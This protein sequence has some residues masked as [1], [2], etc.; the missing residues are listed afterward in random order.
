MSTAEVVTARNQPSD[1]KSDLNKQQD[2]SGSGI[3]DP[4]EING[5]K[6]IGE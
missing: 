5:K 4:T 3:E 1:P 2:Q 6:V